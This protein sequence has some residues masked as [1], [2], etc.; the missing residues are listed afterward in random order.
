MIKKFGLISIFIGLTVSNVSAQSRGSFLEEITGLWKQVPI[1]EE[2]VAPDVDNYFEFLKTGSFKV[3]IDVGSKKPKLSVVGKG[4]LQIISENPRGNVTAVINLN[5]EL[6]TNQMSIEDDHLVIY[7]TDEKTRRLV[8]K[9][10]L[11]RPAPPTK[12]GR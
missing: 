3:S 12:K 11:E 6:T 8:V 10:M 4:F 7:A 1:S 2:E 9:L 5:E